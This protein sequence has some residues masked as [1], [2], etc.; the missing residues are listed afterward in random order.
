M[1]SSHSN[2]TKKLKSEIKSLKKQIKTM[3]LSQSEKF[4]QDV[5]EAMKKQNQ[6]FQKQLL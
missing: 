4:Q 3:Y 5:N 1:Q 2:Q 6:L